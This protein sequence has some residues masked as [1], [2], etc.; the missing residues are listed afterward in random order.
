VLLVRR[1]AL[2]GQAR[3]QPA[4]LGLVRRV[5]VQ[6][7]RRAR[8]GRQARARRARVVQAGH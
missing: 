7:E 4:R 3:A 5:P 2:L 1:V 6:P 8:Q